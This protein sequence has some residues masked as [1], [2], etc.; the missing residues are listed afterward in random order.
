MKEVEILPDESKS[1]ESLRQ[2]EQVS[3]PLYQLSVFWQ[4]IAFIFSQSLQEIKVLS[5]L[6]HP[7]IVQYY[8]SEI[9]S[10]FLHEA[11]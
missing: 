9:V 11:H 6:K 7:N 8:G 10:T 3:V 2:L 5:H 1:A 4:N